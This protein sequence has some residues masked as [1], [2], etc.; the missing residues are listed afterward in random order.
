MTDYRTQDPEALRQR[1]REL[2][3]QLAKANRE[4][5][6]RKA[7]TKV[8]EDFAFPVSILVLGTVVF[9]AFLAFAASS[10]ESRSACGFLCASEHGECVDWSDLGAVCEDRNDQRFAVPRRPQ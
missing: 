10:A 2:E 1:I 7:V 3:A 6:F 5:W 8:Y 9:G 4:P